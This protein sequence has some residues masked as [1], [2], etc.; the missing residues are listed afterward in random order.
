[1]N[2]FVT[3]LGRVETEGGSAVL[4]LDQLGLDGARMSQVLLSAS[5]AGDNLAVSIEGA[6]R[7][8]RD[9]VALNDEYGKFAE[10]T[11]ARIEILKGKFK[12]LAVEVGTPAL[13]AV[14]TV[15]DGIGVAVDFLVDKVGPAASEV[16]EFAGKVAGAG[17]VLVASLG[18]PILQVIGG[19]IIG[20]ATSVEVLFAVLNEIPGAAGAAAAGIAFFAAASTVGGVSA[21]SAAFVSL[22]QALGAAAISGTLAGTG[23][24]SAAA[25]M[26]S[27]TLAAAPVAAV[28]A[29]AAVVA[30]MGLNARNAKERAD[31]FASSLTRLSVNAEGQV[32]MDG[33]A[34]ATLAAADAYYEAAEK[35]GGF[36]NTVKEFAG[37]LPGVS[38]ASLDNALTLREAGTVA[39]ESANQFKLLQ[40]TYATVGMQFGLTADQVERLALVSGIDP[41][42]FL[43]PATWNDTFNALYEV[44]QASAELADTTGT[45]IDQLTNASESVTQFG[46]AAGLT[47]PEI[48][49]LA[50]AFDIDLAATGDDLANA[51]TQMLLAA[52]AARAS[53]E[54]VGGMGDAYLQ[55]AGH[56]YELV[57]AHTALGEV[58]SGIGARRQAMV[59]QTQALATAEAN[60]AAALESGD[61]AAVAQAYGDLAVA[62][63]SMQT[64]VEGVNGVVAANIDAFRDW[65]HQVGLTDEQIG[66]FALN[67]IALTEHE[68]VDL[69]I[70]GMEQLSEAEQMTLLLKLS[71]LDLNNTKVRTD[72]EANTDGARERV[73]DLASEYDLWDQATVETF[74]MADGDEAIRMVNELLLALGQI[75]ATRSVMIEVSSNISGAS[76]AWRASGGGGGLAS[77]AD[78]GIVGY[79]D[80]GLAE[81]FA[82]GG[83]VRERPG[84]A[85]IYRP[86][87]KYRIFAE[88]ETGGEAYIP[89]AASKRGRSRAIWR[90]TGHRLGMFAD[91]GIADRM[92][93][94]TGGIADAEAFANGGVTSGSF[95]SGVFLPTIHVG[96]EIDSRGAGELSTTLGGVASAIGKV[97]SVADGLPASFQASFGTLEEIAASTGLSLEEV[98]RIA[99]D[100][101][102]QAAVEAESSSERMY[103]AFA[104]AGIGI[105]QV[106]HDAGRA[107]VEEMDPTEFLA[108]MERITGWLASD[109]GP[110]LEGFN[111]DIGDTIDWI[112]SMGLSMDE[113]FSTVFLEAADDIDILTSALGLLESAM[114]DT[115]SAARDL[116]DSMDFL[117]GRQLDLITAQNDATLAVARFQKMIDDGKTSTDQFTEA[118]ART[119]DEMIRLGETLAGLVIEVA[120]SGA[121]FEATEQAMATQIETF[122]R[123]ATAAGFTEEQIAKYVELLFTMPA[124]IVT[125]VT[126]E[127]GEEL[128]TVEAFKQAMEELDGFLAIPDIQL[129]DADATARAVELQD[130]LTELGLTQTV[131]TVDAETGQA[132]VDVEAVGNLL[133]DLAGRDGRHDRR[134]PCPGRRCGRPRTGP[135]GGSRVGPVR[136]PTVRHRFGVARC[137]DQRRATLTRSPPGPTTPP[138]QRQIRR[139]A[140]STR[141]GP[142]PRG[143]RRAGTTAT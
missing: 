6:T 81:A 21:V 13:G 56:T 24:G 42:G 54:S 74:L 143:T 83:V 130:R 114:N 27:I 121:G 58:M 107:L 28:A 43:D 69:V 137:V 140:R 70:T 36:L 9:G 2:E 65:G 3:G 90:E 33:L 25:G 51:K 133:N 116:T 100:A 60:L 96:V 50:D 108:Q 102:G 106:A 91:G 82:A 127:A 110:V 68:K 61:P 120:K 122:R 23:L 88:P 38:D 19:A 76:L 132:T 99:A 139:R 136:R 29:F 123:L 26:A 84:T 63:G 98:R 109:L 45:T 67:W 80:G 52:E 138:S 57:N 53:A 11:A 20:L 32:T 48:G 5:S 8:F 87:S 73:A 112:E 94:L 7:A 126:V 39:V 85:G 59:A 66:S 71:M 134:E 46:L 142:V 129:N 16:A 128:A 131:V 119:S 101:F 77:L 78:G 135:A 44:T 30:L 14:V 105:E 18:A 141:R 62:Q 89:L 117:N 17:A 75:P 118:G 79:A 103:R 35:S 124:D 113:V 95:S 64:S 1:M 41:S 40:D 47:A 97:K 4:V 93:Y 125:N 31:E 86:A 34:Q 92:R 72:I 49:Y 111:G 12:A 22:G 115:D 104:D 15:I 37:I 55:A 10:T